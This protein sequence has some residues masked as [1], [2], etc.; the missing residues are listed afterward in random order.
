MKRMLG[1]AMLATLA[2]QSIAT[3]QSLLMATTYNRYSVYA[4]TPGDSTR[5]APDITDLPLTGL[6]SYCDTAT[7]TASDGYNFAQNLIRAS[8]LPSRITM[9]AQASVLHRGS[10][11]SQTWIYFQVDRPIQVEVKSEVS[12]LK[13][14]CWDRSVVNLISNGGVLASFNSDDGS[15]NGS[16]TLTLQPGV[17][18]RFY[19]GLNRNNYY[20]GAEANNTNTALGTLTVVGTRYSQVIDPTFVGDFSTR[21]LNIEVWQN[22]TQVESLCDLPMMPNGEFAFSPVTRGNVTLKVKGGSWLGR[23]LQDVTLT[24]NPVE[25]AQI[26]LINGDI[27]Q[28]GEVGSAD[29]DAIVLGFGQSGLAIPADIDGDNEVGSS[30]YDIVVTNFGASDE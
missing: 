15:Q 19:T 10:A 24:N 11:S 17:S 7:V 29:F 13:L 26:M 22:G 27:D 3:S 18:Y 20:Q 23:T 8:Y 6:S 4:L 5:Y 28:D 1:I 2:A 9:E 25:L 30:D 12:I 14:V 21:T 16:V